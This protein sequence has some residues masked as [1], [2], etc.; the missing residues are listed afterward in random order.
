MCHF[1]L[2]TNFP[3]NREQLEDNVWYKFDESSDHIVP[4]SLDEERESVVESDSCKVIGL[5]TD[6]DNT[7]R[8][9]TQR[10]GE[11]SLI[12]QDPMLEKGSWSQTPDGVLSASCNGDTAKE[13]TKLASNDAKTCSQD[14]ES[15][16]DS[17]SGFCSDDAILGDG[18]A[19]VT[20]SLYQYPISQTDSDLNF[21]DGHHDNKESTDLLDYGWPDIG[22]FEDVDRMFRYVCLFYAVE[23]I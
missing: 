17:G 22:N 12:N 18:C 6:I 23:V 10:T 1:C 9:V 15:G 21:F 14:F 16:I 13:V 19:A 3:S 2:F 11:S 20:D 7:P 5:T 8:C 4:R